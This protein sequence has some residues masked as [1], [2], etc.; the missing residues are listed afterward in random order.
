MT[1]HRTDVL[2]L[3]FGLLFLGIA[4]AWAATRYLN[5]SWDFVW[6]LPDAGWFVAGGLV[7]L[8]VI[9]ILASVRPNRGGAG[10]SADQ[11]AEGERV[12]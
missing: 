9:G 2:S 12:E 4:G 3:F 1:R 6:R 7:L 8:G 5:L 11:R 10:Q